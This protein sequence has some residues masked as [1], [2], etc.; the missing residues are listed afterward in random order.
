MRTHHFDSSPSPPS[1]RATRA[2][3]RGAVS[4]PRLSPFFKAGRPP[5]PPAGFPS[6]STRQKGRRRTGTCRSAPVLSSSTMMQARRHHAA[7]VSGDACW[8]GTAVMC[9]TRECTFRRALRPPLPLPIG[10]LLC[11][12]CRRQSYDGSV[13]FPCP[14]PIS[15]GACLHPPA[16]PTCHRLH[17]PRLPSL[18]TT[19]SLT[20]TCP[21]P[22]SLAEEVVSAK[23][24][25]AFSAKKK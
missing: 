4:S 11:H 10:L 7:P 3:R 13:P 9:S 21:Q 14:R 19:T 25:F 1:L 8:R 24:A 17:Q 2:H 12:L 22:H 6:P 15:R 16:Y 20:H 18:F 5:P 23:W